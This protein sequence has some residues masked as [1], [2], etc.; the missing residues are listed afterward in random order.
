V[1]VPGLFAMN[2]L[3]FAFKRKEKKRK[4]KA[5]IIVQY[6]DYLG[7]YLI[8]KCRGSANDITEIFS[9]LQI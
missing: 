9:K 6:K 7:S 8:P 2:L 1:G 5:C 4:E 3:L